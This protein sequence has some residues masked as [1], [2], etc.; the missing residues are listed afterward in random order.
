MN[1]RQVSNVLKNDDVV[2][3][4]FLGVFPIDRLPLVNYKPASLVVNLDPSNKPG[5]HWVCMYFDKR[6]RCDYFDSYGLEPNDTLREYIFQN[7]VRL[8]HNTNCVQRILTSTCGQMCIYFLIWRC[9]GLSM[10]MIMKS[11]E[12]HNGDEFVTGFINNL[13]K[14]NTVVQDENFITNQYGTILHNFTQ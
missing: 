9:R 10:K 11:L 6:G 3:S 14:I 5:S 7:A 8:R 1:T 13:F 2:S 4:T 12:E